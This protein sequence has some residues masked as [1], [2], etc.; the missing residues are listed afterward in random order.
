[1]N[2]RIL[3]LLAPLGLL[4]GVLSLFGYTQ[5]IEFF[6]WVLFTFISAAALSKQAKN[7]LFLHGLLVGF[8]WGVLNA[9]TQALF[10]DLYLA[11]NP[12][13]AA[14]FAVVEAMSTVSIIL[15]TG[16]TV[17]LFAGLVLGVL[18]LLTKKVW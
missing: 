1:M 14:A 12:K 16:P 3:A 4:M 5:N 2:Y 8:L 17:G 11:N 13:S 18:A 6:L 10:V 9:G 7:R 15:L